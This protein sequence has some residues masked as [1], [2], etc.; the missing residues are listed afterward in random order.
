MSHTHDWLPLTEGPT[1]AICGAHPLPLMVGGR[2]ARPILFDGE[3]ERLA[4]DLLQVLDDP[5]MKA[6]ANDDGV[7]VEVG[8]DYPKLAANLIERLREGR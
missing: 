3:E 4:E 8:Y 1:C 6:Y 5:P 7:M 2:K